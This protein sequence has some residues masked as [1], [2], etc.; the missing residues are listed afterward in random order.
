MRNK[1]G[2]G[3]VEVGRINFCAETVV[4]KKS[5]IQC[6]VKAYYTVDREAL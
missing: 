5:V 1:V 3:R 6:V 2:L 4:W